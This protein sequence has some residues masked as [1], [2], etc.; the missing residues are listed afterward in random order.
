[1]KN[2]KIYWWLTIFAFFF[3]SAAAI[4]LGGLNQDE[5]WYLYAANLVAEGEIPYRD[6]FFTQGPVMPYFYA[7]FCWVWKFGG[8]LG[9]RIFTWVLGAVGIL[10]AVALTRRLVVEDRRDFASIVVILLLGVNLYNLYYL[11]IPKT[12]ALCS[13]FLMIGFYLLSV[14]L[15]TRQK[16]TMIFAGLALAFAAGTRISMAVVVVMVA[17]WFVMSA[18]WHRLV[19]FLTGAAIGVA[20]VYLPFVFLGFSGFVAAQKYHAMRGGFDVMWVVGSISRLVRWYLP[21]FLLFGL[22]LFVH[23]HRPHRRSFE[24]LM[25]IAFA[26]VFVLQLMSPYPYDDY[27]V[28]NMILLAVYVVVRLI[29]IL[30]SVTL[31]KFSDLLLLSVLGLCFAGAFG[32]PLLE[33]WTTNGQDRFWSRKKAQC[34]LAQLRSVAARIDALDPNGKEILTQDLYLAIE[35]NRKVPK[36][37]EMGPFAM[38]NND[39]WKLLL[40]SCTCP[41]AALSGYTFAIN[42]PK[43]NERPIKQQ[44]AYWEILKHNY[45]LVGQEKD[46]GQNA[47]TLLILKHK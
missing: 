11:A 3:L 14:G 38:L 22:S 41:M 27:Q 34:E 25:I 40:G 33:K 42:P 30:N 35:L 23:R 44:M 45:D 6:F 1:M 13:V 26:A 29:K 31:R 7:A 10:F 16:R 28:P 21:V 9:A 17:V 8:L 46:F 5:G 15:D 37:L 32:S 43:C 20:I 39:E 12:Y 36:G 4:W 19:W 2:L 47:T 18:R 24:S